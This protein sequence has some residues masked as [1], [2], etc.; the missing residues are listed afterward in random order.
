[1]VIGSAG[2]E[3]CYQPAPPTYSSGHVMHHLPVF[4]K[5]TVSQSKDEIAEVQKLNDRYSNGVKH[6][7]AGRIKFENMRVRL[8]E[9]K[10]EIAAILKPLK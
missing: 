9:I 6:T 4:R 5:N 1:M 8:E 2:F 3:M 10:G 7:N